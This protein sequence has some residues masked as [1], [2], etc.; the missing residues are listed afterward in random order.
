MQYRWESIPVVSTH[1]DGQL[2]MTYPKPPVYQIIP[3]GK[4]EYK[5]NSRRN[6][7]RITRKNSNW[8][9]SKTLF[10]DQKPQW[11]SYY[12]QEGFL[13]GKT[14]FKYDKAGNLISMIQRS[15]DAIVHYRW[16]FDAHNN[17]VSHQIWEEGKPLKYFDCEN[18][19]VYDTRGNWIDKEMTD[20]RNGNKL[21][22]DRII[23]YY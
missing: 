3:G 5:Y 1:P 11:F 10:K 18:K 8:I 23:L 13:Y 20:K 22:I 14:V 17:V 7:V 2:K 6:T 12:S 19:Y 4:T 21:H 16:T 9:H 15:K